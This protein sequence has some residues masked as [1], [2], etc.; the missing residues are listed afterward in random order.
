[1]AVLPG[2][3]ICLHVDDT[4]GT[5]DDLFKS[6]LKELDKLVGFGLMK[7]QKFDH[8]GRHYEKLAKGE[9]TISTKAYIQNLKKA[10]LAHERTKQQDDE[11][12]GTE[13]HEFRGING[14]LQWVTKELLHP[15]QFV[16]KS[17]SVR[18]EG[19][20]TEARPGS[21]TGPAQSK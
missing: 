10:S 18:C 20:P 6:K 11:L 21:S 5:G 3:L 19:A 8:R 9:I 14:C 1:M 17:L 4:L 16:A 12:S 13:S 7:R 15:F 2:V